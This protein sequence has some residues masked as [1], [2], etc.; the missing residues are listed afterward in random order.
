MFPNTPSRE[1]AYLE[2]HNIHAV[3][4]ELLARLVV[5]QPPNARTALVDFIEDLKRIR[6]TPVRSCF[7]CSLSLSM[8]TH[9]LCF[10]VV[11]QRLLRCIFVHSLQPGSNVWAVWRHWNGNDE[12]RAVFSRWGN[13]QPFVHSIIYIISSNE[14]NW[15]G[16]IQRDARD[17]STGTCVHGRQCVLTASIDLCTPTGNGVARNVRSGSLTRTSRDTSDFDMNQYTH[18]GLLSP[19]HIRTKFR[20]RGRS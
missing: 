19:L 17:N 15:S 16:P 6:D 3:I 2:R 14:I 4:R 20:R 9:S 1:E 18:P 8:A 7:C 5:E 12:L 11:H 13:K 10:N